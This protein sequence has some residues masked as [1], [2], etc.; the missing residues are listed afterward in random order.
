[1]RTT[2]TLP[3]DAHLNAILDL[4]ESHSS[5]I[6]QS[7][8]GSGKTT[9]VPPAML[10]AK[11]LPRGA[12]IWVLLPRRLAAKIA[13]L[14]VAQEWGEDVGGSIGYQF[15][16]EGARSRRTQVLFLT[17]G[18][19]T[20]KLLQDPSLNKV[21]TVLLDEF[22]ERSLQSDFALAYLRWL[23]QCS[24]P[25]LKIGI[26]SATLDTRALS[27]ALGNAPVFKIATPQYEVERHYLSQASKLP[28]E[29]L[30]VE[31]LKKFPLGP[32]ED[33]LVFLPGMAEIRRTESTL[34]GARL[35]PM[36]IL[37]LHGSLPPVQQQRIFKRFSRPKVVLATNI[38]ESSLTIPGLKRV[39]D[40]G[41][42]RQAEYS[43]WSGIPRLQTRPISQ[44][45]AEQRAGRAGRTAPGHCYRLYTQWDLQSR[46]HHERPE[47]QRA[48]LS[49]ML[50]EALD[51]GL[52]PW[53]ELPWLE[54]PPRSLAEH[55]LELLGQLGAAHF[56]KGRW[57]ITQ[58][59]QELIRLPLHPR[60]GRLIVEAS[61]RGVLEPALGLAARLS[62][63]DMEV[64]PLDISGLGESLRGQTAQLHR[65]LKKALGG[66][67]VMAPSVDLEAALGMSLLKAFPDRV[68][69]RS[70]PSWQ[71]SK[72]GT[73]NIPK[74]IWKQTQD[75]H[76]DK[77]FGVILDVGES[78]RQGETGQIHVR[79]WFPLEVDRLYEADSEWLKESS[80]IK[81]LPTEGRLEE[82]DQIQ[83]GELV[84]E[85]SQGRPRD[86]VLAGQCFLREALKYPREKPWTHIQDLLTSLNHL[87]DASRLERPLAKWKCLYQS[88]LIPSLP[89]PQTLLA[90]KSLLQLFH[91]LRTQEELA[92]WPFE[93]RILQVL[94]SK[95]V[96]NWH[97]WLPDQVSLP[98]RSRVRVQYS[99]DQEPFIASRLQDFFGLAEGPSLLAG[100]IPLTLK[101]LA[102]N[103]RPVQVTKDL[104]SFWQKTYPEL[105]PALSRRYP[106]H[107]WPESP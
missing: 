79:S 94:P 75:I 29:T 51:L 71:F 22:H 86:G 40:T 54:P 107:P 23:Q 21:H 58:L 28:M 48:D 92:K 43:W 83:Y 88:Q 72:G 95:A 30:V 80:E 44:A 84:L 24:R 64:G 1:M 36:E 81:W 69:A 106:K 105:R 60:L 103:Q 9:R 66:K 104:K 10:R 52:P 18:M 50:L 73:G 89:S 8:P 90:E 11:S 57:S 7:A 70:G 35:P 53:S 27:Q 49:Q 16:F 5:F 61:Q 76:Q 42:H 68:G 13:A 96:A 100:R 93:E 45:S 91:G 74:S 26:M 17:E 101:L 14:R 2:P 99:W 31:H 34:K 4:W 41:W 97:R 32:Q 6:L 19:F 65:Q 37:P 3:I 82:V 46:P 39:I 56:Q 98:G 63:G 25:D 59:G 12:Q 102:P 33:S 20:R 55:G 77:D 47:I 38:A 67:G 62:E 78:K 85:A 87:S 15:R